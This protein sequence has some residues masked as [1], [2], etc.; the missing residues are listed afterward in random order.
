MSKIEN[1]NK[2]IVGNV[3]NNIPITIDIPDSN[4]TLIY[5]GSL[6]QWEFGP[7][8]NTGST[9]LPG[10]TGPTGAAG[11]VGPTGPGSTGNTGLTGPT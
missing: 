9:G 6:N 8:G 1:S 10:P 7:V 4:Q 11:S 5:N 2:I 3:L